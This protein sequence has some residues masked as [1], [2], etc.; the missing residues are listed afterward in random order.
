MSGQTR[1]KIGMSF[2]IHKKYDLAREKMSFCL[3]FVILKFYEGVSRGRL[4]RNG[5]FGIVNSEF[6]HN[7]FIRSWR[8]L[9]DLNSNYQLELPLALAG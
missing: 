9:L 7:G 8:E 1:K 3:F 2:K 4:R 6:K 5:E